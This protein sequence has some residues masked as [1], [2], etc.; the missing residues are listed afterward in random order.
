ML[1]REELLSLYEI[2]KNLLTKKQCEYFEY[3]YYEDYSLSEISESL[4]V[5]KTI[6]GK[7]ITTV[8]EKLKYYE[9]NIGVNNLLKKL[10]EISNKTKDLNTKKDLES[11]INN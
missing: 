9:E 7:T 5:S 4:K 6:I 2:Y 3:Y 8:N 11:L 10:K 1:E